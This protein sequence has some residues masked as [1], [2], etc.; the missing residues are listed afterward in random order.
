[1][2]TAVRFSDGRFFS[3]PTAVAV[4]VTVGGLRMEKTEIA[5]YTRGFIGE[6]AAAF[7][8]RSRAKEPG[9]EIGK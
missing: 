1:L 8:S 2:R 6:R 9:R 5:E 4:N 7:T 3:Q